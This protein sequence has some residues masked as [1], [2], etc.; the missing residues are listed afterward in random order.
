LLWLVCVFSQEM[1]I[2][3]PGSETALDISRFLLAASYGYYTEGSWD[4]KA[5]EC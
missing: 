5:E 2:L 3:M 4:F 1:H